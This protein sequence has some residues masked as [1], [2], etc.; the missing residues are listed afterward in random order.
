V[1]DKLLRKKNT[2]THHTL[3]RMTRSVEVAAPS[4]R[5][6]ELPMRLF[7]T[8]MAISFVGAYITAESE[9]FRLLH[10][11]LGYT[12]FGLIIFRLVWGM[13][14]PRQTRL[15]VAWR[16]L[17]VIKEWKA[18]LQNFPEVLLQWNAQT[19]RKWATVVL[20]IAAFSTFLI[21]VFIALSGY[22]IYNEITG[23]WM[24]EVHEFFGNFLLMAVILHIA[25]ILLLVVSKK[26]QGL[27]PMWSGRRT[28]VGPDVAKSNHLWV[29]FLL[30][31]AVGSFLFFQLT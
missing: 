14:G 16:K 9:R 20:T 25:V 12:L 11:S 6:V 26:S 10:V 29:A 13:L 3:N 8:F 23:D 1:N 4:R 15:S 17:D 28:G 24:S 30:S 18:D 2:M 31:A 19:L 27:R 7:H 22:A 21:S 5:I